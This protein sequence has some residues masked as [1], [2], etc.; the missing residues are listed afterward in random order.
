MLAMLL[1]MGTAGAQGAFKREGYNFTQ[2]TNKK[3][4]AGQQQA[5]TATLHTYTTKDGTKYPIYLSRNGRAF[6][7]RTSKKTGNEYRQYLG[8]EISRQ[9]CRDMNVTYKEK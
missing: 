9:V 3:G 6:I 1:T 8:E 2:V 7:I 5:A 4:T